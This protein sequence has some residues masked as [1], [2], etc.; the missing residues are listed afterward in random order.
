[1]CVYFKKGTPDL[2]PVGWKRLLT[3]LRAKSHHRHSSECMPDSNLP[4]ALLVSS[5]SII[6][7]PVFGKTTVFQQLEKTELRDAA[8]M[9]HDPFDHHSCSAATR[10]PTRTVH[11]SF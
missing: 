11:I 7:R 9:K 1:M 6:L 4:V 10:P 3:F 2:D 5:C 8:N